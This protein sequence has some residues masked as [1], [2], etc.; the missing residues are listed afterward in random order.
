MATW[1]SDFVHH[2]TTYLLNKSTLVCQV[3]LIHGDVC[4]TLDEKSQIVGTDTINA[5]EINYNLLQDKVIENKLM[6][7]FLVENSVC[8]TRSVMGGFSKQPN[9][10]T[11][12][13]IT[14]GTRCL[15]VCICSFVPSPSLFQFLI[16][17]RLFFLVIRFFCFQ[18][19][20]SLF[21]T[22]C[23]HFD[24]SNILIFFPY[25]IFRCRCFHFT[26]LSTLT[27]IIY[28]ASLIMPPTI[29]YLDTS[30]RRC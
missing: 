20:I 25:I 6:R 8:N 13:G 10:P 1:Q 30:L 18:N 7:T 21:Q 19:H 29:S 23:F 9:K 14:T 3:C 26:R 4:V 12:R 17:F 11:E 27:A 28:H 24:F 2:L 16:L 22:Y 5:R 15:L